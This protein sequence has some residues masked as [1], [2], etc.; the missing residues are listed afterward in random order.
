[1]QRQQHENDQ[2]CQKESSV[3]IIFH[4]NSTI[5][6]K[7]NAPAKLH[8]FY[9]STASKQQVILFHGCFLEIGQVTASINLFPT[10]Y[11]TV[12]NIYAFLGTNSSQQ[13]NDDRVEYILNA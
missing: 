10:G 5:R 9:F 2:C 6:K 8:V 4:Q 12:N 7:Q 3:Y 1:M 13:N 11:I